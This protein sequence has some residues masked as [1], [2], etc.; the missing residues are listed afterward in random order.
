MKKHKSI[1]K[2]TLIDPNFATSTF[3][4]K[5]SL[6]EDELVSIMKRDS[7]DYSSPI[8]R[9]FIKN[10]FITSRDFPFITCATFSDDIVSEL[11]YKYHG[12]KTQEQKEEALK[13]QKIV[14]DYINTL[15]ADF[16]KIAF[17][18]RKDSECALYDTKRY[19]FDKVNTKLQEVFR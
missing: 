15:A 12:V 7:E 18:Y 1:E 11:D 16:V 10:G 4:G 14:E 2:E 5:P 17:A 9:K 13:N 6:T 19:N 3:Y 8:Y